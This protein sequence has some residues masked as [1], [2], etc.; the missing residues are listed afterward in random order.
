MLKNFYKLIDL[1]KGL[2]LMLRVENDWIFVDFDNST[3]EWKALGL[4]DALK[5]DSING[6]PFDLIIE[7]KSFFEKYK[8]K[9]KKINKKD[10]SISIFYQASGLLVEHKVSLE[11]KCIYQSVSVECLDGGLR[12]LD[13]I[14]YNLSGL[15]LG[16]EEDCLIQAPGQIIPPDTLYQSMLDKELADSDNEPVPWY[17]QGWLEQAPDQSSGLIAVENRKAKMTVSVWQYSEKATIFP[18]INGN[19]T[20]I[21]IAHRHQMTAWLKPGVV[22]KSKGHGILLTKTNFVEHLKEFK[23]Y[24]YKPII[25]EVARAPEWLH[26][27]RL[28]QIDPRPLSLWSNRLQEY[29]DMGF[30]TIY[31]LPVWS[32]SGC[33]YCILDHYQIDEKLS[34]KEELDKY[35]QGYCPEWINNPFPVGGK[36]ELKTFVDDAHKLDFKVLFDFIPQGIGVDSEFVKEHPEWLVRDELERPFASHGWGYGPGEAIGEEAYRSTY[37]LDW[38]NPDYRKFIIDWAIWNV[39]TFDIDGYR[40]DAMHWKEANLSLKNPR[41]AWETIYGGVRLAEELKEE[42]IKIKEDAVLISEVW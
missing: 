10:K 42:L 25:N 28:V 23:S 17:P 38:G 12:K 15:L 13:S 41:K 30:N 34:R 3:G 18:T 2:S 16:N 8:V 35:S 26:N 14:N 21:D 1:G 39:K 27:A 5:I 22:V 40:T 24:A 29:K 20:T 32:N 11:K 33:P 9:V 36:E 6:H 7:G 31:M 19:G 4:N 37:S